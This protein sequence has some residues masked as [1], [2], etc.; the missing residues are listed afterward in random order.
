[1]H[2][3]YSLLSFKQTLFSPRPSFLATEPSDELKALTTDPHSR[4]SSASIK[5]P[6][7]LDYRR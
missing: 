7:K 2:T 1:M 5:K 4:P 6:T 3:V